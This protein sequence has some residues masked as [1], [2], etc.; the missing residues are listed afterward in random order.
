MIIVSACLAGKKCNYSGSDT[1][2]PK[3]KA[4]IDVGEAIAVCPEVLAGLPTPR[5]SCEQ[6][7]GKII[8]KDGKDLTVVFERGAQLALQIAKEKQCTKAILKSYSPSC[9]SDEVYDGTFTH[10]IVQGNGVFAQLLKD[11]GIEVVSDKKTR[12][13]HNLFDK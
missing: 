4:L 9:G 2:C 11:A 10:T 3:V 5:E 13:Q 12:K 7:N 6:H 1:P 8:T